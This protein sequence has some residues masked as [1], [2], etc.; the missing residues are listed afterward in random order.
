MRVLGVVDGSHQTVT[1]ALAA[2]VQVTRNGEADIGSDVKVC[3]QQGLGEDE[4]VLGLTWTRVYWVLG[5]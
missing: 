5:C 4:M 2:A 1:V 3:M